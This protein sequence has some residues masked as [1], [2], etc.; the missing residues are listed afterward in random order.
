MS[1]GGGPIKLN[2]ASAL[3]WCCSDMTCVYFSPEVLASPNCRNNCSY[4]RGDSSLIYHMRD[5]SLIYHMQSFRIKKRPR[6]P[7]DSRVDEVI[8]DDNV[9]K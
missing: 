5:S 3:W 9:N 7:F 4:W 8:P 6:A 1:E 2:E